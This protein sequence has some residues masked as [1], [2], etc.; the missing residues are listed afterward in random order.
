LSYYFID[1]HD[2]DLAYGN[3]GDIITLAQFANTYMI[4]GIL[5]T[6]ATQVSEWKDVFLNIQNIYENYSKVE[7]NTLPNYFPLSELQVESNT[8]HYACAVS[9]MYVNAGL[10]GIILYDNMSENYMSLWNYSNTRIVSNSGNIDYGSTDITA[11]GDAFV[12]FCNSKGTPGLRAYCENSPGYSFFTK[13]VN[14]SYI[15]VFCAGI[16]TANGE[17]GHAMAVEGYAILRCNNTG[18]TLNTIMVYDGWSEQI[19]FLNYE[20]SYTFK[21]GIKWSGMQVPF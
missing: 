4:N 10:L 12:N 6:M 11:I 21:Y 13:A 3:N 14:D 17:E 15:S 9:A 16:N 5:D 18:D 20:Y 19:A 1:D 8:K 2:S 7:E